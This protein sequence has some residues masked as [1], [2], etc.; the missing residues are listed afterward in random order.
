MEED[1]GRIA[2]MLRRWANGDKEALGAVAPVVYQELRRLAHRHLRAERAGHTLQ[3][4]G[5]VNEAFIRLFEGQA[6]TLADRGHFIAVASRTMRPILVEYARRRRAQKRD[7]GQRIALE[8]VADLP[9]NGDEDLLA[10]DGALEDLSRLD[11][12]QGKIVEMRFFG[13]LTMAEI[14]AVLGIS[15]ATAE[16]DWSTA[17]IWLRREINRP[18]AP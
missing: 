4:T 1:S 9:I 5:L 13:G 12:R 15:V 14:S 2:E 17:R 6:C 8:K 3:S 7:G 10:L 11:E 16:R 18:D